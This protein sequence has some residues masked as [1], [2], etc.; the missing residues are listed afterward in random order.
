[1]RWS[2]KS[3]ALSLTIVH[4]PSCWNPSRRRHVTPASRAR[5]RRTIE[6]RLLRRTPRTRL[7]GLAS[8]RRLPVPN[9]GRPGSPPGW[10]SITLRRSAGLRGQLREQSAPRVASSR[11]HRSGRHP[12]RRRAATRQACRCRPPPRSPATRPLPSIVIATALTAGRSGFGA[13][14]HCRRRRRLP[15]DDLARSFGTGAVRAPTP[16]AGSIAV[17]A[18]A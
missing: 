11:P 17:A 9:S 15:D 5:T 4:D 1:V 14:D 8:E 6:A 7:E 3:V 12:S 18:D 16:A 10:A 2:R 13:T